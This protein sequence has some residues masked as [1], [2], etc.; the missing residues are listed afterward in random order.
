MKQNHVD[1]TTAMKLRLCMFSISATVEQRDLQ[2][3]HQL[4]KPVT[5]LQGN[6]STKL[7]Y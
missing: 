6:R 2:P 4:K 7:L 1:D 5:L 3:G